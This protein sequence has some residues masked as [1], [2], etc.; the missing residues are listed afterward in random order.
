VASVSDQGPGVEGQGAS[1]K[2]RGTGSGAQ[3]PR[4]GAP[5]SQRW[6]GSVARADT[7]VAE[8]TGRRP[9]RGCVPALMVAEAEG[10]SARA[11]AAPDSCR[12][13][14]AAAPGQLQ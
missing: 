4:V 2:S 6:T 1:V 5:A 14:E 3:T 10:L 9:A 11:E 8:M 13:S 12:S 7:R